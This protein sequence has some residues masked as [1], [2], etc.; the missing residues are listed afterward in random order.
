MSGDYK[1]EMQLLAEEIALERYG[2][3]FYD[4]TNDQQYECF[5]A[6]SDRWVERA[7]DRADYLRKSAR[8]N[9]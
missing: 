8:E 6:G 9:G 3:E 1:Y 2:Q 5:T 7:C 4:L